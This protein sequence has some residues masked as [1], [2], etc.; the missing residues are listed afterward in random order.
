MRT[1]LCV[2]FGDAEVG[3]TFRGRLSTRPWRNVETVLECVGV[4]ASDDGICGSTMRGITIPTSGSSC[5]RIR[6]RWW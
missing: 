2:T 4:E 3:R 5:R 6:P 1:Q